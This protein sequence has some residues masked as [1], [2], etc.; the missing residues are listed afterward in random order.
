MI[1]VFCPE[2][3]DE[4]TVE[5]C[6][7]CGKK[8]TC[9]GYKDYKDWSAK[10]KHTESE[11]LYLHANKA[12]T[13]LGRIIQGVGVQDSGTYVLVSL[14]FDDGRE[15]VIDAHGGAYL[16]DKMTLRKQEFQ[17]VEDPAV[18]GR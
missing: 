11:D 6:N 16:K 13:L 2:I 14:Y 15:L 12:E 10:L 8:T 1:M 4:Q 7:G 18:V 5:D 17:E 3:G 9:Q